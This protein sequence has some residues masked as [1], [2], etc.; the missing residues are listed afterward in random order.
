[1][2][3]HSLIHATSSYFMKKNNN[4]QAK[5]ILK[6][7]KPKFI[8]LHG[9]AFCPIFLMHNQLDS[10]C[11]FLHFM[12]WAYDPHNFYLMDW[13]YGPYF[14]YIKK[15]AH[16]SYF[17]RLADKVQRLCFLFNRSRL[18]TCIISLIPHGTCFPNYKGPYLHK[19]GFGG[20][21]PNF[22]L[23]GLFRQ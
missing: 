8:Q 19:T 6:T 5:P 1:M 17:S 12:E 11:T 21:T 4:L 18:M 15:W 22:K 3:F 16:D 23:I 20:K 7:K 2:Q 14:I 9:L 13:A 10:W